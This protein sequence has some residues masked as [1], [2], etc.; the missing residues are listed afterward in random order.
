MVCLGL[1]GFES[2][3]DGSDGHEGF[4]WEVVDGE[5]RVSGGGKVSE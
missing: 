5:E 2:G 1:G 3:T 4:I